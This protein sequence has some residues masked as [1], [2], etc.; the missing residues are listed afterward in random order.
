M[1]DGVGD[2]TTITW[3][4]S[5]FAANIVSVDGPSVTIEPVESTHLGSTGWKSFL[6]STLKDGGEL[7]LTVNHDAGLS[8]PTASETITIDWGGL[9]NTWVFSGI[10]TGYTPGAS[11]NEIMTATMTIKVTGTITG[12]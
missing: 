1:A 8:V 11:I 6:A 5:G 4:S 9:G 10:T 12:F 2:G 7:S 3:G